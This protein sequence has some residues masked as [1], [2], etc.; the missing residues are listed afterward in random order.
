MKRT[1]KITR[2][3]KRHRTRKM[4]K[5]YRNKTKI[6]MMIKRT[7][8]RKRTIARKRTMTGKIKRNITRNIKRTTTRKRTIQMNM[9]I[10]RTRHINRK[11]NERER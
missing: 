9:V 3:R 11:R 10:Y 7:R 8:K 5:L 6:N 2:K 4:G 1:S